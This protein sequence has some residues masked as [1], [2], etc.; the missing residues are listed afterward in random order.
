MIV[1]HTQKDY[2]WCYK[3]EWKP[4][5]SIYD[6]Q[7]QETIKFNHR[8]TNLAEIF[9]VMISVYIVGIFSVKTVT[10][11]IQIV[12]L[13]LEKLHPIMQLLLHPFA[14]NNSFPLGN[15]SLF[16]AS[17]SIDILLGPG[18]SR[19]MHSAINNNSS[20]YPLTKPFDILTRS[21]API[22]SSII[23]G[24]KVF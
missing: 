6:Q 21:V 24:L 9:Q 10:E 16:N 8:K 15:I 11:D 1:I 5:H 13:P 17:H 19:L 20:S 4:C 23:I 3:M 2:F 18:N 7:V 14:L 12:N 22:I